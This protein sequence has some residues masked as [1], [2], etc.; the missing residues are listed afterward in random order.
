MTFRKKLTGNPEVYVEQSSITQQG[1]TRDFSCDNTHYW[2]TPSGINFLH[3]QAWITETLLNSPY[4]CK[5][6]VGYVQTKD[7]DDDDEDD[8]SSI[9]KQFLTEYK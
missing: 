9:K 4:V 7:D 8:K 2:L 5:V 6:Y 1:V 3:I